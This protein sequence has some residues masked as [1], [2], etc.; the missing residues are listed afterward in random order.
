MRYRDVVAAARE[1]AEGIKPTALAAVAGTHGVVL[2]GGTPFPPGCDPETPVFCLRS[3]WQ[4]ALYFIP[5]GGIFAKSEKKGRPGFTFV[6]GT[7][8]EY[9]M[10]TFIF[11]LFSPAER[12]RLGTYEPDPPPAPKRTPATY[13][14]NAFSLAMLMLH[15]GHEQCLRVRHVGLSDARDVARHAVSVVGHAD[16]ANVFAGILDCPV[17]ANRVSVTLAPGDRLL[18]GQYSGP[19]LPEGTTSLPDGAEITWYLVRAS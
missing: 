6:R 15:L 9:V 8:E 7:A 12:T 11:V 10:E 18:V 17:A 16:T 5:S 19:R 2:G 13:L 1:R 4:Q 3:G 14:G